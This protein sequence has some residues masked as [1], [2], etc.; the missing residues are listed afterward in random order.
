MKQENSLLATFIWNIFILIL[1]NKNLVIAT[2]YDVF[3]PDWDGKP[4]CW[5]TDFL[6][7]LFPPPKFRFVN[8]SSSPDLIIC[9]HKKHVDI[10]NELNFS[11]N[12]KILIHL[13]DEFLGTNQ[14]TLACNKLYKNSKLV[15]RQYAY[16]DHDNYKHLIQMP[17]GYM[18]NGLY[19]NVSLANKLDDHGLNYQI[20]KHP[21][22]SYAKWSLS[23][24]ANER[25]Y[26]WSFIGGVHGKGRSDRTNALET[27]KSWQHYFSGAG[28]NPHDMIT[29]IYNDSKFI[30]NGRGWHTID[31][32]R[33]YE[34][35]IAGAIPIVVSHKNEW[36][37]I[38]NYNGDIPPFL[39]ADSWQEALNKAQSMSDEEIDLHREKGVIWY[40][41]KINQIKNL[42]ANVLGLEPWW[43]L[44]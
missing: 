43:T 21:S 40:V 12:I 15:L 38:F 35:I 28:V 22:T 4:I 16:H 26:N 11:H 37:H 33:L 1:C 44:P 8:E 14:N 34:A 32:F 7:E 2:F 29:N 24:Q 18:M 30:V 13:S 36:E 17:L 6:A 19:D 25:K 10:I 39:F 20:I 23:K 31:C 9:S 5:T 42:S 41:D 3:R 27:F